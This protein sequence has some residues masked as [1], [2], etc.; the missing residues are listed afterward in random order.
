M[1]LTLTIFVVG[2]TTNNE[3][4][5]PVHVLGGPLVQISLQPRMCGFFFLNSVWS[6]TKY[7]IRRPTAKGLE[8]F[9]SSWY[10]QDYCRQRATRTG[11]IT[12]H[13]PL[14]TKPILSI[15]CF[16][17]NFF[18]VEGRQNEELTTL[19]YL[20]RIQF[21]S[22][23]CKNRRDVT[24]KYLFI[25]AWRESIEELFLTFTNFE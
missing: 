12:Y 1:E 16:F 4:V 11:A 14:A 20:D 6:F 2:Q 24:P 3:T 23:N 10:Q 13:S 18:Q 21:D 15:L 5:R 9:R 8:T 19:G 25:M 17:G 7:V 22:S